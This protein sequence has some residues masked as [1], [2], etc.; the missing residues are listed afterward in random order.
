MKNYIIILAL[1]LAF[2][3]IGVLIYYK[4]NTKIFDNEPPIETTENSIVGCFVVNFNKDVYTLNILS[5]LGEAVKGILVFKNF[6]KD[7]S[8][9]TFEGRYQD[10]ILLGDYSFRSEGTDSVV[11]VIFKRSGNDFIRGYGVM[12][13]TGDHFADLSNIIYDQLAPL[14]VFKSSNEDCAISL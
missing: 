3:A 11:Q 6:E 14:A 9:G 10:G 4:T 13:K 12:N 8:S 5:Q 2:G 1:T 7:S